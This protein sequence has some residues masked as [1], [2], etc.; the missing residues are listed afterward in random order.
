MLIP[1]VYVDRKL[2]TGRGCERQLNACLVWAMMTPNGTDFNSDIDGI[3]HW[4]ISL[5]VLIMQDFILA[6][7]FISHPIIYISLFHLFPIH[8]FLMLRE[9]CN[10]RYEIHWCEVVSENS[11]FIVPHE[12]GCSRV[13]EILRN[14]F[15]N[16]LRSRRLWCKRIGGQCSFISRG[17]AHGTWIKRLKFK[18][19]TLIS[20]KYTKCLW[21]TEVF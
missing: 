10:T 14:F 12:A 21:T 13:L 8:Y 1:D 16:S 11:C 18:M 19:D 17:R 5:E 9:I 6:N 4:Y 2:Y 3:S 20:E 7:F 15:N